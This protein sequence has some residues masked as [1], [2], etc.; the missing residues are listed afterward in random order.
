[1]QEYADANTGIK[2]CRNMQLDVQEY[3]DA[4]T[5]IKR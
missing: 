5:G 2:M 4:N 3:A 1:V